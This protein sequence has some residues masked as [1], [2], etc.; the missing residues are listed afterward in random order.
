MSPDESVPAAEQNPYAAPSERLDG[1]TFSPPQPPSEPV[2]PPWEAR[3]PIIRR[4]LDTFRMIA[5]RTDYAFVHM[6]PENLLAGFTYAAVST[7]ITVF[8]AT[9]LEI[10]MLDQA[11][12]TEVALAVALGIPVLWSGYLAGIVALGLIQHFGMCCLG[13]PRYP[14]SATIKAV[15]YAHSTANL[16]GLIPFLGRFITAWLAIYLTGLGTAKMQGLKTWKGVVTAM[17][18]FA[19]LVMV[20]LIML[21]QL[22]IPLSDL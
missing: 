11:L 6:Q 20:V 7:G 4:Y 17:V 10:M 15:F 22:D 18:G 3:G 19:V 1:F 12:D 2:V 16:F 14:M 8:A 21:T 13:K 5:T 9:L